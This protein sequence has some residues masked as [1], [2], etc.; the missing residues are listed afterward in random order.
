MAYNN[1]FFYDRDVSVDSKYKY[2]DLTAYSPIYGSSVNYE[3]RLNFLQTIDNSLK[4]LPASENNLSITYN[5]K[6]LLKDVEVGNLLKTIEIAGAT[7][8]LKFKDPSSFYLAFVGYVEKYSVNK[9]SENF[10]EVNITAS[11]YGLVPEFKWQTSSLFPLP[12]GF[13]NY[14]SPSGP[15]PSKSKHSIIYHDP[16]DNYYFVPDENTVPRS[17]SK[18]LNYWWC[19]KDHDAQPYNANI[20]NLNNELWTK[21]FYFETKYPFVLEN[22]IDVYKVDYKNSFIQNIK[23]KQNSNVLKQFSLRFENIS[24]VECKAMLL[25][26]EKKSGYRRFIYE[27]PDFMKKHKVFVCNRWNH[28]FKYKNSHDVTLQLIEDPNPNI[29]LT[30]NGNY[31][32]I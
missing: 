9:T 11:N 20:K 1:E 28:L 23:Y 16:Y 26:L 13:F 6:F 22:E 2:T 8:Y 10:S 5:L 12:W 7:K 18:I 27:F 4:I 31:F 29:K 14:G 19:K 21:N 17:R 15:N 24:D 30:P 25:F 3:S 32:L